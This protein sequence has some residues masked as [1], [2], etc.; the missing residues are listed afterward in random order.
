MLQTVITGLFALFALAGGAS[1]QP[2]FAPATDPGNAS[3]LIE[4][5]VITLSAGRAAHPVVTGSAEQVETRV[6]G[7]PE[8]SDLDADGVEDAAVILV[9][10]TGGSGTFLYIAAA[11]RAQE[12]FIG[13]NAVLL[14]D[15]IA[16]RSLQIR[17]GVLLASYADR[18]PG[19]PMSAAPTVAHTKYLTLQDG[20][21]VAAPAFDAGTE[22]LEGWVTIGHEVSE[23]KPCVPADALWLDRGVPGFEAVRTAYA[24]TLP[25]DAGPDTPVFMTL[26]GRQAP[27]PAAGFGRDYGAAFQVAGWLHPW[28]RGN[29]RADQ[30]RVTSPVPGSVVHSPLR[31]TGSARGSW[32]FEADFPV[33]LKDASGQILASGIAR[34]Q[35][36]WMTSDFV[37]F[38]AT[39]AF[40]SSTQLLR[41]TLV[42]VKDNPS[43]DPRLDAAV[44]LPVYY[45]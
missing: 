38:E 43:D 17:N 34:A 19:E 35:A 23:F 22:V 45:Q 18:Q 4:D 20:K 3:Y 41:G 14:G 26:A 21:L 36:P 33:H 24:Q 5:E 10:R 9:H 27:A 1:A 29:C 25:P 11:M 39:I 13:T 15:R 37:P 42:L 2:A 16:P 6:F 40:K 31:I 8:W 12:G 44:E 28:P 7:A 30:I 32:F